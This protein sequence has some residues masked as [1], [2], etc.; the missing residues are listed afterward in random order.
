M[1]DI[2]LNII[3]LVV[4]TL[5][6]G[7][8]F[9]LL[10]RRNSQREEKI[11]QLAA[12]KG[13]KYETVREPLLWGYR[14]IAPRWILEALSRSSGGDP[15]PGSSNVSMH[16]TWQATAPG[17]TLLLGE[18]SSTADL[19]E[20][21]ERLTRA[22]LQLALGGDADGLHEVHTGSEAFRRQYMLWAQD[23]DSFRASPA[24]ESILLNWKGSKPLIKRTSS[25]L[26]VELRQVHLK[27]PASILA[28][29]QLGE[30]F[31]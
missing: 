17:G 6:G 18:R 2:F 21:G 25:T 5:L 31:L 28:L 27:D 1:N 4:L 26:T 3:V 10:R 7:L 22:V 12:E 14:L 20:T 15:S 30:L 16:T 29:V 19:G 8:G 9:L 13:W 23:P 24:I 11:I